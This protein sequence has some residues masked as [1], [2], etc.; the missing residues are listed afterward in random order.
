MRFEPK[1]PA[2][3]IMTRSPKPASVQISTF[4]GECLQ[5]KMLPGIEALAER[6]P[7][8]YFAVT[9]LWKIIA[10]WVYD[11]EEY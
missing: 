2:A 7:Q 10:S 6:D 5:E 11:L 3:M 9:V 1:P 4:L 8:V